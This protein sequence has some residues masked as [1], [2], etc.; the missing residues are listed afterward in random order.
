MDIK[1]RANELAQ[2]AVAEP[3]LRPL[4]RKS[5][6]SE[7]CITEMAELF[8]QAGDRRQ[9]ARYAASATYEA[10]LFAAQSRAAEQR[11]A[12]IDDA[13]WIAK[14]ARSSKKASDIRLAFKKLLAHNDSIVLQAV[15]SGL[16]MAPTLRASA[17]NQKGREKEIA[18]K[19]FAIGKYEARKWPS[20][21]QAA[22]ALSDEVYQEAIRLGWDDMSTEAG[23]LYLW[24]CEHRR[25]T[26]STSKRTAPTS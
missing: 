6:R 9:I 3:G 7:R 16:F 2:K 26:Q 5:R 19:K 4:E 12:D 15:I 23:T 13:L 25:T 10:Q 20:V 8:L 18:V 17:S 1:S 11:L 21:K 24:L 14:S 22:I